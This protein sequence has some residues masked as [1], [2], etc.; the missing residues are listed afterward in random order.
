MAFLKRRHLPA[1]FSIFLLF[2]SQTVFSANWLTLQGT[3]KSGTAAR[4]KVWGFVQGQYQ[5]DLS[6]S[7]DSDKYI[8]PKLIGPNL[9]SQSMFNVNRARIGVRGTGMPID[10]KIN[11]FILSELGN[12]GITA[13]GK[14]AKL[15]DGSVTLN[16]IPFA[17]IRFGL[18]KY[19]GSEEGL[20]AIHVFD[21]INFTTVTNQLMLE[22]F[23]NKDNYIKGDND[24]GN[25]EA[26]FLSS[27][28]NGFEQP[29]GAFRDTGLQ[30]FDSILMGEWEH[31]YAFMIGN[32]NGLN[33]GDNNANKTTYYYASSEKIFSG[34]GG[35][36]QGLKL[37]A[38]Y[39]TG[40]RAYDTDFSYI[41]TPVTSFDGSISTTEFTYQSSGKKTYLHYKRTRAGVGF[42]YLKS[43]FR[44]SAEYLTGE[45]MIFL[46]PHKES[47]DMNK[48]GSTDDGEGLLGKADGFYIDGGWRVP[49]SRF[50]M[51]LRFDK[52]NRLKGDKLEVNYTT[53][54]IGSQF[55]LNKKS[56][57]TINYAHRSAKSKNNVPALESNFADLK[58]RIA[59]QL[60]A[61]Y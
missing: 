49:G 11:Y 50:E 23:P 59:F 47:F 8:P 10:S 6:K 12:N 38:W 22:R 40:L 28:A 60:T 30:V 7:N 21:Y 2:F 27:S 48:P 43:A 41:K 15:T 52:Y 4:A 32:G 58:G 5:Y 9:T 42:K 33:F 46:G 51:D 37:F 53:I 25:T 57:F 39:Q 34:Q 31:S 19:P 35:R 24:R 55:V 18:F 61:I 44:V 56:R 16:H 1:C 54:T 14:R 45:G 3:E 20:Q 17:R 26:Q 29:V 36:R 13:G